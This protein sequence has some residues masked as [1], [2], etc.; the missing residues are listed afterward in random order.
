VPQTQH[1]GSEVLAEVVRSDFVEGCHRGSLVVLD[2]DGSELWRV[3]DPDH[4][5]FPR[6]AN[7]PVQAVGM[8]RAGLE[9]DGEL[10]AL[11]SASHSGEAFHLDGVRRILAGAGLDESALQTPPDYP[12]DEQEKVAFIRSGHTPVPIAMNCSGKHAAMLATCVT[13]GW[14]LASYLAPDHPLQLALHDTVGDLA[15]EDIAAVGVDG[16]GAPLF[17]LTL[18]GLARC[19]S[20]MA[21]ALPGTSEARVAAAIRAHPEWLG[22][23]R[24]DVS[25]LIAAV[26]GLIAKDGAEGVYAVALPD[27]RAV[28]VKIDDGGQRARSPVMLA[29]L[30][31]LGVD[32]SG[33]EDLATTPLFGGGRRVGEIRPVT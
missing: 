26:P 31:R 25:R 1:A 15:G 23:T 33:L 3:G 24:R 28:A 13:N 10:L 27:G 12:V 8:L 17:A 18:T 5:V 20:C 14:P 11:A 7:K 19:F 16:C 4:P 30:H 6:S 2:V 21:T 29:V 32:V 22:G 9:L